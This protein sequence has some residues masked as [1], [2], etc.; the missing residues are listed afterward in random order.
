MSST[1]CQVQGSRF[2][3]QVSHNIIY[4]K[5]NESAICPTKAATKLCGEPGSQAAPVSFDEAFDMAIIAIQ[6]NG[7]VLI[8]MV[9]GGTFGTPGKNYPWYGGISIKGLGPS[10]CTLYGNLISP[11]LM[12]MRDPSYKVMLKSGCACKDGSQDCACDDKIGEAF[13]FSEGEMMLGTNTGGTSSFSAATLADMSGNSQVT[14]IPGEGEKLILDGVKFKTPQGQTAITVMKEGSGTASLEATNVK[15]NGQ[16]DGQTPLYQVVN[17]GTGTFQE[18]FNSIAFAFP[19]GSTDVSGSTNAAL[20]YTLMGASKTERNHTGRTITSDSATSVQKVVMEEAKV[21]STLTD[22]TNTT[23]TGTVEDTIVTGTASLKE[24]STNATSEQLSPTSQPLNS[25]VVSDQAQVDSTKTGTTDIG[26]VSDGIMNKLEASGAAVVKETKSNNNFTNTGSGASTLGYMVSENAD[27]SVKSTD[28]TVEAYQAAPAGAA[29]KA[30]GCV[31]VSGG[32]NIVSYLYNDGGTV[33]F[34]STGSTYLTDCG[35]NKNWTQKA[36]Q[37]NE[38]WADH[39]SSNSELIDVPSREMMIE[40]GQHSVS[41]TNSELDQ[42]STEAAYQLTAAADAVSKTKGM[43][44][45]ASNE[46]GPV[47]Q[48]MTMDEATASA[49]LMDPTLTSTPPPLPKAGYAALPDISGNSTVCTAINTMSMNNSSFQ[50]STTGAIVDACQLAANVA[51]DQANT[52]FAYVVAEN[53]NGNIDEVPFIGIKDT[54]TGNGSAS[55]GGTIELPAPATPVSAEPRAT[56]GPNAAL[57]ISATYTDSSGNSTSPSSREFTMTGAKKLNVSNL[58]LTILPST[59]VSGVPFAG[60]NINVKNQPNFTANLA[61]NTLNLLGSSEGTGVRQQIENCKY[62]ATQTGNEINVMNGTAVDRMIMGTSQGSYKSSDNQYAHLAPTNMPLRNMTYEGSPVETSSYSGNTLVGLSQMAADVL[63]ASGTATVVKQ[64]GNANL[65]NFS[66]NGAATVHKNIG[67]QAT[68]QHLENG[69]ILSAFN[70][71]PESLPPIATLTNINGTATHSH[72]SGSKMTLSDGRGEE[73]NVSDEATHTW[74]PVGQMSANLVPTAVPFV[75][76]NVSG[77]A[78]MNHLPMGHV[79]KFFNT[80]ECKTINTTDTST[81]TQNMVGRIVSVNS[82]GSPDSMY[83]RMN[84]SGDSSLSHFKNN[85]V[86]DTDGNNTMIHAT[87]NSKVVKVDNGNSETCGRT[88]TTVM[89]KGNTNVSAFQIGHLGQTGKILDSTTESDASGNS[90]TISVNSVTSSYIDSDPG[91]SFYTVRS[92]GNGSESYLQ[93]VTNTISM[94]PDGLPPSTEPVYDIQS[95]PGTAPANLDLTNMTVTGNSMGSLVSME[96]TNGNHN[97]ISMYGLNGPGYD[98]NNCAVQVVSGN[99]V[100]PNDTTFKTRLETILAT[101]TC[102]TF[103]RE[104]AK[105]DGSLLGN[106]VMNTL[107]STNIGMGLTENVANISLSANNSLNGNIDSTAN[108]RLK[109]TLPNQ[110]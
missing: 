38:K 47:L 53:R 93:N 43:D 34:S 58:D 32:R 81:Y 26:K 50:L 78:T 82:L 7:P 99:L 86:I 83:E 61:N 3:T 77:N 96:N 14:F 101:G 60:I 17:M 72:I 94:M 55:V 88:S 69:S 92:N 44:L 31:D 18:K 102:A 90:P 10:F 8:Q 27:L 29:Y 39:K 85:Q 36:G 41:S 106:L 66:Q 46:G 109:A 48:Y 100:T 9:E 59:D 98:L 80:N 21:D 110:V 13:N 56:A 6:T 49:S 71:T 57:L 108:Q 15:V 25:K 79:E 95:A 19:D 74:V 75:Q 24:T 51:K 70:L 64:Q 45:T 97:N 68:V 30:E 84:P 12:A 87:D 20:S 105:D 37:L 63:S 5:S 62:K 107:T 33:K 42:K 54:S 28:N 4:C 52:N 16:S 103:G 23:K 73:H 67:D 91:T 35:Q 104:F 22:T 1:D 2:L 65:T 89:A 76:T 11:G 40:G